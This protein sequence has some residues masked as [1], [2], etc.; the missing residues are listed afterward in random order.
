MTNF[1]FSDLQEL[2]ENEK[3]LSKL[4]H[5]DHDNEPSKQKEMPSETSINNILAYSKS[6]SVRKSDNL[7]FIENLLN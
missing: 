2:N 5:I 4:L 7:G 3:K 1:T 6:L